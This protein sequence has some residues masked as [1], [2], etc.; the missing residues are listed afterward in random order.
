MIAKAVKGRGFRG[1][2]AYDLGKDEGRL[3]DTN[4]AGETIPELSAEFGAIRRLRPNLERA[5]LHVSLS[6]APGEKLSDAQWAEIGRRYLAGMDF[7]DN[8]Y[9]IS[10]HTDT[11]HEHIHILANRITHAGAVVSDSKDYER[12]EVLMRAIEREF[13]LSQ[14]APSIESLRK[15]PTRGEI[16]KQLRTSEASTRIQL[17][18][19]AD[20]AAKGATTYTEYQQRLEA[21]GVQLVPVLQLGGA[22]LSGLMYRLD[23]VTMKGSDLGKGYSPAGLAKRGV[24]YEQDRDAEAVSRGRESEAAR[25]PGAAG[26]GGE[27]RQESERG[28]AGGQS[29]AAGAGVGS[30]QQ[31]HG[32]DPGRDRQPDPGDGREFHA[33]ARDRDESSE[34]SDHAS[35]A[36]HRRPPPSGEPA[37]LDPLRPDRLDGLAHRGARER[38]LALAPAADGPAGPQGGGR[39][40]QAGRDLGL[41]AGQGQVGTA[42]WRA[43]VGASLA[44]QIARQ[45]R[46][47]DERVRRV[48][49]RAQ[50]REARREEA[51]RKLVLARP[52]APRGLLA[53]FQR[54]GHDQAVIVWERAKVLATQLAREAKAL[55]QRLGDMARPERVRQWVQ[56]LVRQARP[57]AV[58]REQAPA[59]TADSVA[60][61]APDARDAVQPPLRQATKPRV[62]LERA[63]A[64]VNPLLQKAKT[65]PLISDDKQQIA[66]GWDALVELIA[67]GHRQSSP[68]QMRE[69]DGLRLQAHRRV[70]ADAF[71]SLPR[72]D[73]VEQYPMLADAYRLLEPVGSLA[74]ARSLTQLQRSQELE[75]SRRHIAEAIEKGEALQFRAGQLEV[76]PR[77]V[78]RPIEIKREQ[79]K[80]RGQEPPELN[81]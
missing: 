23:G 9:L 64:Q 36:G 35:P 12:Q 42:A 8:Q 69:I 54:K 58:G 81:R 80:E 28:R 41:E 32:A 43:E 16:E 51:I 63:W 79:G 65:V 21:S 49:A 1:A 62:E 19:L 38:I 33:S 68:E 37:R 20:V 22:K 15:P 6:A 4:M 66:R 70:A 67:R 53:T 77:V 2:I 55:V 46:E 57:Q 11:E 45:A 75:R 29:R 7:S 59:A 73:V 39:V 25:E 31:R 47:R 3:L 18:Q 72:A 74:D 61:R 27:R 14:L 56:A 50:L 34:R 48:L 71:L 17:Q 52:E 30:T 5:V 40:P 24:S 13:G 26:P 76:Q 44:D 78:V 60:R 10:R